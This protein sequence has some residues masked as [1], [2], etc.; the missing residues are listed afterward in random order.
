MPVEAAGPVR[1]VSTAPNVTEIIYALGEGDRLVGVTSYCDYPPEART[2]TVIGDF[3]SPSMEA[4]LALKPDLVVILADRPD[5]QQRLSAF[6]LPILVLPSETLEDVLSSIRILGERL[7]RSEAAA[8]LSGRIRERLREI[9]ARAAGRRAPRVFFLVS[10]NM[11]SLTDLYTIGGRSYIHDLVTRAG[12]DNIFGSE[13]ATYPKVAIEE[14]LARNPEI[15]ID[16]SHGDAGPEEAA[17]VSRLWR[18]FP[19]LD[20]VKRGRVFA[21]ESDVFIVPGPRIVDAAEKLARV[22]LEK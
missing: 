13:P 8:S 11:G 22:F 7:G 21:M 2:K 9:E 15:I 19:S 10:R 18:Q 14:I 20:A 4:I 16:M 1:I 12:G 6:S 17:E 3:A 5:L